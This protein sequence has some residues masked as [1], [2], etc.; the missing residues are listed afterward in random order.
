ML[1]A[2][3]KN[4]EKSLQTFGHKRLRTLRQENE[5]QQKTDD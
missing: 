5:E 3:A 2:A 4:N 1:R